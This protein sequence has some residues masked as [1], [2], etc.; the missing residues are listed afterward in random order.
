ML[1]RW[2][3]VV[4]LFAACTLPASAEADIVHFGNS[5]VI[6]E[7]ES[8]GDLVCFLCSVDAKSPVHGD[9]VVFGGNLH[10][11]ERAGG[12][13]VVFAGDVSLDGDSSIA[14]DL[15]IFGG[16][17]H[18]EESHAIG[19]DRVIFPPVIFLPI[20]LVIAGIIWVFYLF[21]RWLIRGRQVYYPTPPR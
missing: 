20:L 19:G 17:L 10:L 2:L 18:G 3:A 8:A 9:I 6:S 15:V 7:G 4:F 11:K 13:V 21:A 14:H 1:Q 5:I 16:S 12:D